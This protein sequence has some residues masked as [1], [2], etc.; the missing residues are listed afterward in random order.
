MAYSHN[1][2]YFNVETN[3]SG[4]SGNGADIGSDG[5]QLYDDIN[6]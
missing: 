4:A 2:A 1:P 3:E 6:H 5:H